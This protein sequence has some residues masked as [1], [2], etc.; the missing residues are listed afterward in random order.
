[1]QLGSLAL[2]DRMEL[3]VCQELQGFLAHHVSYKHLEQYL[4]EN[5]GNQEALDREGH[6]GHLVQKDTKVMPAIVLAMGGSQELAPK[7]SLVFPVSLED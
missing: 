2:L 6:Q 3:Q 5:L 7:G 4:T 1:M